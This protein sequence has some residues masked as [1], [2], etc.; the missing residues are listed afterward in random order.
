MDKKKLLDFLIEA[1]AK[2]YAGNGGKVKP[3]FSGSTQLEHKKGKY[4]YRDVYNMGNGIFIGLETIYFDDKPVWSMSYY[5]DFTKMTEEEIDKIL[6][7]A[8]I[9]F[10]DKARLWYDIE[11]QNGEFK[12]ICTPDIKEGIEHVAGLEE[13]YKGKEKVYFFFYAGGL[14]G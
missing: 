10:K 7:A 14:I 6:R 1:G 3:A 9:K 5:G 11:W 13:I 4:F 8:L 2:T 12:Y